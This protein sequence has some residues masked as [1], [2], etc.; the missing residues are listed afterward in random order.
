MKKARKK[1]LKELIRLDAEREAMVVEFT[2]VRYK[3]D[4]LT[5]SFNAAKSGADLVVRGYFAQYKEDKRIEAQ[6]KEGC[7]NV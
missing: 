7:S 4:L 2:E 1:L 3:L 6:K 5:E